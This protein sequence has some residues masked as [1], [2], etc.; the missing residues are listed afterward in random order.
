MEEETQIGQ[1]RF[2]GGIVGGGCV[3][4]GL[5]PVLEAG[6]PPRLWL[7]II[8]GF[9]VVLTLFAPRRLELYYRIWMII[10]H[11]MGWVS[12]KI[13]LAVLFFGLITVTG[14]VMRLLG[15]DPMLRKFDSNADT[16]RIIRKT[17]PNSH[18]RRLF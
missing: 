18:M 2:F 12:T 16:Y 7:L 1:L 15:K 14:F 8:A 5:L 6:Q 4:L 11:A 10:G 17:R 9:L 3:V 13:I